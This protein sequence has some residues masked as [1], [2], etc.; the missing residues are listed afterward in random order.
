MSSFIATHFAKFN[1]FFQMFAVNIRTV[2]F[3]HPLSKLM[4]DLVAFFC[5]GWI[6]SFF[7]SET[8]EVVENNGT[9]IHHKPAVT[10]RLPIEK[11]HSPTVILVNN[12]VLFVEVPVNDTPGLLCLWDIESVVI[13]C[14]IFY[15]S[16]ALVFLLRFRVINSVLS[17][18]LVEF[19]QPFATRFGKI[20]DSKRCVVFRCTPISKFSYSKYGFGTSDNAWRNERRNRYRFFEVINEVHFLPQDLFGFILVPGSGSEHYFCSIFKQSCVKC[21]VRSFD[22]CQLHVIF[23]HVPILLKHICNFSIKLKQNSF[24]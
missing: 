16:V 18:C 13:P 4:G 24:L 21:A 12:H 3:A 5:S 14:T 7:Q 22:I 8:K 11:S 6:K 2:C 23:R 10:R 20:L 15:F 19:F 17:G 9:Y 1:T